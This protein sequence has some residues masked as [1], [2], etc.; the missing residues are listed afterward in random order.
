M[1]NVIQDL[2]T[3]KK[4]IKKTITECYKIPDNTPSCVEISVDDLVSDIIT[5]VIKYADTVR[6]EGFNDGEEIMR[7][8]I[9][10]SLR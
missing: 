9:R 3:L 7:E 10:E 1:V 8:F 2:E 5:D 6:G 4:E